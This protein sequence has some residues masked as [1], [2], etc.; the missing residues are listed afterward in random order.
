MTH[1]A[2]PRP[3]HPTLNKNRIGFARIPSMPAAIHG[4]MVAF[5]APGAAAHYETVTAC[6][7]SS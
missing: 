4:T 3:H 1:L 2:E 5:F 7:W 6:P